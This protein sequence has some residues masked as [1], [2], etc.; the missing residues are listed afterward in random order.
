M[1]IYSVRQL[2]RLR[3]TKSVHEMERLVKIKSAERL[4]DKKNC[5]LR[6]D[7]WK[8]FLTKTK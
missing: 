5:S 1:F 6:K 3:I 8:D 4:M 7:G 2:L